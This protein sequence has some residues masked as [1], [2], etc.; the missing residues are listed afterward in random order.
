MCNR[1]WAYIKKAATIILLCNTVVQVMQTFDWSFQVAGDRRTPPS[2]PPHR[3]PLRLSAGAHRGRPQLAAGRRRR[4][5]LHRQG[6][7]GGHP[8]R[9]L[10]GSGEP[11]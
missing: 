5:R 10:R 3:R 11:D 6:E 7:R 8:G 2:W 4:H 1:G 9:L